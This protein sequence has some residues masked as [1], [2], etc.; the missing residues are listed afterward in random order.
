MTTETTQSTQSTQVD[1]PPM[2]SR[3]PAICHCGSRL[4]SCAGCG[5]ARCLE[6]D[7]YRSDDCRW[8]V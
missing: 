6:C 8:D 7:P 3:T 5:D 1:D 4:T 2:G